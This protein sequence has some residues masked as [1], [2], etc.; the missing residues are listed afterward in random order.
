MAL[1]LCLCKKCF[2]IVKNINRDFFMKLNYST[3]KLNIKNQW[4]ET[5]FDWTTPVSLSLMEIIVH[6]RIKLVMIVPINLVRVR[7]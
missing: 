2:K 1:K 3:Q 5:N 4:I 7:I 6:F